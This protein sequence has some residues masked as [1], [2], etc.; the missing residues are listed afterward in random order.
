MSWAGLNALAASDTLFRIN[1][2]VEV[3]DLDSALLTG[4]D[5]LHAADAADFANLDSSRTTVAVVASDNSLCLL[6]KNVNE[7]LWASLGTFAA[8][9]TL[10]GVNSRNTVAN[11]D[12]AE[13]TGTDAVAQT[14]AAETAAGKSTGQLSSSCTALNAVV[15]HL[16][17]CYVVVAYTA[18]NGNLWLNVTADA[19]DL[20]AGLGTFLS[21]NRAGT[22]FSLALAQGSS[23][24]GTTGE[25][26]GTA[27][28]AGKYSQ[29]SLSLLV[30]RHSHDDGSHRKS[31]AGNESDGCNNQYS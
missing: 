10:V 8:G 7:A 13:L 23:I 11:L 25:S 26:A 30:L 21:A 5:A 12:T 29:N 2:S 31:D 19:E 16:G 24:T 4:L 28:G 3:D 27:V 14:Q 9:N 1:D 15:D 17:V 18:D 22:D 6:R 20:A